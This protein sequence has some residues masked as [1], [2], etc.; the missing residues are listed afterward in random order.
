MKQPEHIVHESP[1]G[2]RRYGIRSDYVH[3]TENASLEHEA[4]DYWSPLRHTLS[5]HAQFPIYAYAAKLARRNRLRSVLD[6]GCGMGHKLVE[7]F[8][9]RERVVGVDQPAVVKR[10][11]D[12]PPVTFVGDDFEQ[13]RT[14]LGTFD[15][16]L[17]SGV[18]E[19]VLDPD[20]LLSYMKRHGHPGSLLVLSTTERVTLRGINNLKSP[21]PVHVREWAFQEFADYLT[22]SGLTIL[23]HRVLPAFRVRSWPMI[24]E[25]WWL[26][27]RGVP[28]RNEQMAVCKLA[29]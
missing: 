11:R 3:R 26:R 27:R 14:H 9:D 23:E 10:L 20:L 2:V 25:W 6:V 12:Q 18:I 8:Q 22:A 1:S 29:N 7:L 13:P 5:R 16:V 15:L 21:K 28:I 17:S 19:H 4:G 24:R